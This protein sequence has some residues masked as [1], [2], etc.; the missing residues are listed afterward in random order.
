MN[1]LAADRVITNTKTQ[2]VKNGAVAYENGAIVEVG[3]ADALRAKFPNARFERGAKNSILSP[4]LINPHI[5]L[6]FSLNKT[7]FA[8][9]GFAKWL[10]TVLT[11]KP[12]PS[13]EALYEV[14]RR[15]LEN[16]KLSGVGALGAI[17][18]FGK[19]I[20]AL[21]NSGL[22]A[23][24]FNEVL[25]LSVDRLGEIKER[26]FARYEKCEKLA[27]NLLSPAISLHSTY[28]S[29][30]PLMEF[31]LEFAKQNALLVSSHFMESKEEREWLEND[32]GELAETLHKTFGVDKSVVRPLEFLRMFDGAK[33]L[34]VHATYANEEELRYIKSLGGAL[35]HCPVSNRLL[36]LKPFDVERAS[37]IGAEYA[38]ATDGLSSNFSLNIWNEL[39]VAL[40][41]YPHIDPNLL[42]NELFR[43]VTINAAKALGL[44][45]G[46]LEAG[47][48]ADMT[49]L[50]TP[51]ETNDENTILHAILHT[52]EVDRLIINGVDAI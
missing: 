10:K 35:I 6:E 39:R 38:I 7:S 13:D 18:S 4:F 3:D 42:A 19:D 8:Y 28:S 17:S 31:T 49:L 27:S 36:G 44:N 21:A 14:M 25:G 32:S 52:N 24:V 9:G 40:F 1:I 20:E 11:N 48:N 33:A 47:T 45:C 29:S 15:E 26:F 2:T 46:K 12:Q 22:R 37:K 16:I 34:F 51:D 50:K 43:G 41:S 30:K 23:T 5:H